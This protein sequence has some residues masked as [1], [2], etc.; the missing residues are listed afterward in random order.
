MVMTG[1][2]RGYTVTLFVDLGKTRFRCDA[3]PG[4]FDSPEKI[5]RAIDAYDLKVRKQFS[6]PVAWMKSYRSGLAQVEVTSLDDQLAWIKRSGKREKV[7]RSELFEDG[8]ALTAL[9]EYEREQAEAL[10]AKWV[11]LK[12]WEP[13]T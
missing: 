9:V 13:K 3:V 12:R 1:E 6:N 5:E 11:A 7:R 10:S 8:E 4:E 2:H